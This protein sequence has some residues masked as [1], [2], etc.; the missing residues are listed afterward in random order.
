MTCYTFYQ[1][2]EIINL[3]IK[4]L[5]DNPVQVIKAELEESKEIIELSNSLKQ[6]NI[7]I[8]HS[9]LVKLAQATGEAQNKIEVL[10]LIKEE[11]V[12]ED[13]DYNKLLKEIESLGVNISKDD[14]IKLKN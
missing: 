3:S 1:S 7:K 13:V 10:K 6:N 5:M 4:R 2:G 12:K 14:L 11:L 9:T 8:E